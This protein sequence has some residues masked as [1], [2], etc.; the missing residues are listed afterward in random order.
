VQTNN[1][2]FN[3]AEARQQLAMVRL[4]AVEHGRE[5]LMASTVGVSAFVDAKGRVYDATRF[6]DQ[7]VIE[8]T[9]HLGSGR[10]MAT[11]LGMLPEVILAAAAA[12]IVVLA[13]ALR[14][15]AGRGQRRPAASTANQP[16]GPNEINGAN[17]TQLAGVIANMGPLDVD[18]AQHEVKG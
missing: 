2:T 10:T 3:E 12:G 1:A 11:K 18:V 14:V 8:R 5:A 17:R 7:A 16:T 6:M 15:R 13:I 4:R 9:V